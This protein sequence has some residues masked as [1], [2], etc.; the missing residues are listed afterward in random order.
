[1]LAC[2]KW[3]SRGGAR[4]ASPT[5]RSRSAQ[6]NA[7]RVDLAELTPTLLHYL[8][9]SAYL[10]LVL[11]ENLSRAVAT[12]P[13]AA[14]KEAVSRVAALSL[15]KHHALAGLIVRHGNQPGLIM[16]PFVAGIEDFQRRTRGSDWAEMLVTCYIT[17]GFLDDFFVH[18]SGG[19]PREYAE[20]VSA[21]LTTD[22]GHDIL[23]DL[24]KG[25]IAENPRIA[26]RLALWGRR[27]IGDTMLVARSA[28]TPS[29]NAT[30]DEERIEPIFTELIAEHS[31][32]MDGLGLTA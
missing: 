20:R 31:R 23:K 19:L 1:M 4:T 15:D 13:T 21:A 29:A 27:L 10:Q 14:D 3:F 12:A 17:A 2:V 11:F 5:V 6:S 28:L 7:R 9:Q 30:A 25:V 22:N 32:R 16:D 24:L 26:S 8:G 18:L